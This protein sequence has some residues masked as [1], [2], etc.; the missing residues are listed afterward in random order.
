MVI[1]LYKIK[2]WAIHSDS[3]W[4]IVV[5]IILIDIFASISGLGQGNNQ[6]TEPTNIAITVSKIIGFLLVLG[7]AYAGLWVWF[8]KD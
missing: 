2:Q 7:N 5:I 4:V 1:D 6:V 8:H 3:T